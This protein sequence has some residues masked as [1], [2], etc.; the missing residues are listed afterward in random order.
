[1]CR[2]SVVELPQVEVGHPMRL[3]VSIDDT[4]LDR[5]D[6]GQETRVVTPLPSGCPVSVPRRP[7]RTGGEDRHREGSAHA[8][9]VQVRGAVSEC[10]LSPASCRPPVV[11]SG[12]VTQDRTVVG[13]SVSL[14]RRGH[15]HFLGD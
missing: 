4:F 1:M 2:S 9:A 3:R 12:H 8:A 13:L 10:E 5:R 15:E 11:N 7:A 14:S 6:D